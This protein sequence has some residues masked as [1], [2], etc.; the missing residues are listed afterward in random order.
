MSL[1]FARSVARQSYVR[2]GP[3]EAGHYDCHR[4]L[5]LSQPCRD[6]GGHHVRGVRVRMPVP[7]QTPG[8]V[9]LHQQVRQTGSVED[10]APQRLFVG[11][12]YW[13]EKASSTLPVAPFPK[14]YPE[15]TNNMP[16]AMTGPAAPIEPPLAA[17]PFTVSKSR[18]VLYSHNG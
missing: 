13:T 5:V 8:R 7:G 6:G 9:Y 12:V 10:P 17:T 3:A 11:Q 18:T 2:N 4:G 14:V 15:P 16:P 1:G